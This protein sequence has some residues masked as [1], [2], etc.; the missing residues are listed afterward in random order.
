MNNETM[1][2]IAI[3]GAGGPEVLKLQTMERPQP[4]P[5]E[6]L[7]KVHAAGVNRPDVMQR[8]GLYPPPPGASALPGLEVAG[9]IYA[10]GSDCPKW[11]VGD[12]VVA[13]TPGGGYAEY[14]TAPHQ[15]VLPW[16]ETLSPAQA[17]GVPETF[18]TVW[19]NL[20]Q[21]AYAA[22]GDSLLVHGGSSGIGST[23]ILL[24]KAFG[25]TVYTTAGSDEKCSF[26]KSLGADAAINYKDEK[27]E[28]CIKD[29]TG[30]KGVDVVLDMIGGDYLMRNVSCMKEN[31]RHVTI[32]FQRGPKTDINLAPILI[33]RLTLTG[34]TLRPRSIAF[35]GAVAAEL[36]EHVWPL[37]GDGSVAPVVDSVFP[38]EQV[39]EA[40]RLIDSSKHMGKI[41][42]QMI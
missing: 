6:V 11:T 12:R 29:L 40:H 13:L 22:D 4:G 35:K 23:T 31:G 42:L 3:D 30:G 21:R 39:A 7:I 24:G 9:E 8:M 17:A 26:A 37:L 14:V 5:G 1:R 28:D 33:K 27:F 34:S 38:I 10:K 41:I 15:Q 18:F 20:F 19:S 32:A 25:L 36:L 16:P 2:A